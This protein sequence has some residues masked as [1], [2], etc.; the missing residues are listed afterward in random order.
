MAVHTQHRQSET[1]TYCVMKISRS[2]P[3]RIPEAWPVRSSRRFHHVWKDTSQGCG[4]HNCPLNHSSWGQPAPDQRKS[5]SY[6][7]RAREAA[8]PLRSAL[9]SPN[10]GPGD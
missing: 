6:C 8:L 7:D 3:G 5:L 10:S 1:R 9:P 2:L 4:S